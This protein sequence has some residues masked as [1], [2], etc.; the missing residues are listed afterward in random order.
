VSLWLNMDPRSK[1]QRTPH[2]HGPTAAR[3]SAILRGRAQGA[4]SQGAGSQRAGSQGNVI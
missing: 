3:S 4:G 2:L 1:I